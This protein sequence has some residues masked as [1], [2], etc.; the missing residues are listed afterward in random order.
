MRFFAMLCFI[1]A[2]LAVAALPQAA[3]AEKRVALVIGNSAYRHA[4]PLANPANDAADIA[5]KLRELGF[6]VVLGLD[7]DLDGLRVRIREFVLAIENVD[8]A[9]FY[10]AGHGLQVDGENYMVPVDAR[11]AAKI[12]LE[13]EALPINVVLS[14]MERSS[15]TNLIFLDACRNNPLAENLA[16][17]MGTRAV[18][19]GRGLARIGSG[20]GSLVAFS[21]QPGN[22]ALDGD[23]RNSPFTTALLKHL[24]T[25]GQDI[26]RDLIQ[27]RRDV[28]AATDGRQVPW[29]NSSLTGEVVLN[30][31]G[32]PAAAAETGSAPAR[33]DN[34]AE[35]AYWD[36]IKN[37]N[38]PRYFEAY[39]AQFPRGV[40]SS[41]ARLK[42]SELER[43]SAAQ[44]GAAKDQQLASLPDA[45][46]PDSNAEAERAELARAVQTE[47]NRV[48]CSA[49]K[50]DGIWGRGSE[51]ALRDFASRQGVR[52]AA[53]EPSADILK[54]L[55]ATKGRAC[56]LSCG[57]GTEER[58]GVCVAVPRS[59]NLDPA[60]AERPRAEPEAPASATSLAGAWSLSVKCSWGSGQ[61]ALNVGADNSISGAASGRISGKNVSFVSRNGL[62]KTSYVGSVVSGNEMR[63]TYKQTLSSETCT[64]VAT[65]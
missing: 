31:S 11:L 20:V 27:V 59:A 39:L 55:K 56:P 36:S 51:R 37:A 40:F 24:G 65:R 49:G 44:A 60:P 16:R 35:I 17:S 63:G 18:S 57:E 58:D 12:D 22:V 8:L 14:A 61:Y 45:A 42:I 19:V 29:E 1:S 54:R 3:Q 10:Y 34:S 47:L 46:A 32:E 38:E 5:Q 2:W 15:R 13:F 7:L 52:L 30:A 6:E 26:T 48:G 25:P 33:P 23:G 21:T 53:I 41:L 64:W 4:A 9:L 50:V 43:A 28:L 62:N